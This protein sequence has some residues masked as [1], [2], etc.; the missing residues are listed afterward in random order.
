MSDGLSGQ[1]GDASSAPRSQ[2]DDFIGFPAD[3][4]PFA[5]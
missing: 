3:K 2:E 4:R 1:N 5:V